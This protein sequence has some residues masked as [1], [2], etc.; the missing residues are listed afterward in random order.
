MKAALTVSIALNASLLTYAALLRV[1][2]W[3][4]SQALNEIRKHVPPSCRE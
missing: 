3:K 2:L 4:L 1:G